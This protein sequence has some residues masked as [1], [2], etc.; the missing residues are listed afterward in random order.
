MVTGEGRKPGCVA[1]GEAGGAVCGMES[2]QGHTEDRKGSVRFGGTE[3]TGGL[4]TKLFWWHS[5]GKIQTRVEMCTVGETGN[6]F[7]KEIQEE[8]VESR[9][10]FVFVRFAFAFYF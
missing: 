7:N 9:K 8:G 1:L 10:G 4:C 3:V 2:W 6:W 5:R